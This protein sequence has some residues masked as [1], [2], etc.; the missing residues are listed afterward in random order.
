M[1]QGVAPWF[2]PRR[3][4]RVADV[5]ST[6]QT[7]FAANARIR[8]SHCVVAN[9]TGATQTVTFRAVDDS[10]D[11]LTVTLLTGTTV[12]VPGWQVDL[13]G[14]EVLTATA[15]AGLHITFFHGVGPLGS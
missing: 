12:V 5:T 10:P 15:T 9:T 6:P 14:I 8:F 4:T 13:E 2:Y 7:A 11:V 3:F 1:S